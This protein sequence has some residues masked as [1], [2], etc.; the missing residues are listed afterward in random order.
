MNVEITPAADDKMVSMFYQQARKELKGQGR[1]Q[2]GQ[3]KNPPEIPSLDDHTSPPSFF[4][5]NSGNRAHCNRLSSIPMNPHKEQSSAMVIGTPAKAS[6][7]PMLERVQKRVLNQ[8][9]DKSTTP[10]TKRVVAKVHTKLAHRDATFTAV[11]A[12]Y[13]DIQSSQETS[14]TC[15]ELQCTLEE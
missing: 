3:R 1:G 7:A 14:A 9:S 13:E 10:Q 2:Q 4:L 12:C 6:S 15:I 11:V 5:K 8:F